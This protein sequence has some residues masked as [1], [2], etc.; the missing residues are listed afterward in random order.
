MFTLY[1]TLGLSC[2]NMKYSTIMLY[3]P[4]DHESGEADDHGEGF[5]VYQLSRCTTGAGEATTRD[6]GAG[7]GSGSGSTAG[8][9]PARPYL[10]GAPRCDWCTRPG[11]V[12]WGG[13]HTWH[14]P[15][16]PQTT[17]EALARASRDRYRLVQNFALL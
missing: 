1:K 11:G 15:P 6:A 7:S 10:C 4:G 16:A 17:A 9:A 2:V 5:I 3:G 8:A 13:G 14:L 12:G